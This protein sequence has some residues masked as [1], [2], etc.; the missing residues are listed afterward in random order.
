MF[1]ELTNINYFGNNLILSI[2]L[3]LKWQRSTAGQ[4]QTNLEV[5][6]IIRHEKSTKTISISYQILLRIV[7]GSQAEQIMQSRD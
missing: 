5:L 4:S 6:Q 3:K 1:N 2:I 7:L